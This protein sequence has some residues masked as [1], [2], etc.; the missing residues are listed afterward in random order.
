ML[1]SILGFVKQ[2]AS[3]VTQLL[4]LKKQENQPITIPH[5]QSGMSQDGFSDSSSLTSL[6]FWDSRSV[7]SLGSSLKGS[8][9]YSMGSR[10][11]THRKYDKNLLIGRS[12]CLAYQHGT[13]PYGEQTDSHPNG[14]GG[15]VIHYCGLCET[16]SPDNQCYSPA[17]KCPGPFANS[18]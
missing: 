13:C 1:T 4:I 9:T 8:S 6:P 14:Q 17:Y 15:N 5:T 7:P 12:I 11:S 2:V 3:D 10:L 18:Y 16:D